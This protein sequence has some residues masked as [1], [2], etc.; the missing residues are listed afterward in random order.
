MSEF[1]DRAKSVQAKTTA[2]TSVWIRLDLLEGL[3]G[4]I[5]ALR[6]QV[7][8]LQPGPNRG[9]IRAIREGLEAKEEKS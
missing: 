6:K 8:R 2:E 5:E 4:D 9:S 7:Q 1:L 3:I